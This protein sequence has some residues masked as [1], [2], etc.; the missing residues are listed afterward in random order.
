MTNM[1]YVIW[2]IYLILMTLVTPGLVVAWRE[3]DD[4]ML[5]LFGK[6]LIFVQV[7][8]LA[9]IMLQKIITHYA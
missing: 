8:L 2:V 1:I 9:F 4:K 5:L 7:Y 6:L 3:R